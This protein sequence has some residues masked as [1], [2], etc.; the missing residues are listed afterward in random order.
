MRTSLAQVLLAALAALLLAACGGGGGK[1]S[2]P[3]KYEAVIE[4][5]LG[6]PRLFLYRYADEY[7]T[8]R[9]E[10]IWETPVPPDERRPAPPPLPS[11]EPAPG[12]AGPQGV[13]VLLD[14]L[15]TELA[16][17][18]L[19][20]GQVPVSVLGL[21]AMRGLVYR[22]PTAA[23]QIYASVRQTV[24]EA[25]Y[26]TRYAGTLSGE[27]NGIFL[28]VG[29][30]DRFGNLA[31]NR[32]TNGVI[33]IGSIGARVTYASTERAGVNPG[34]PVTI[35]GEAYRVFSVSYDGL[36][37]DESRRRM[38]TGGESGSGTGLNNCYPNNAARAAPLAFNPGVAGLSID[39]GNYV[40]ETCSALYETLVRARAVSRTVAAPGFEATDF[41]IP[42]ALDVSLLGVALT[43]GDLLTRLNSLCEGPDAWSLRVQPRA[44]LGLGAQNLCAD[45]T[46]LH[47][48]LFG[49][50]GVNV[51]AARTGFIRQIDGVPP[52]VS[53]G[54]VLLDGT[55]G[56][57]GT[58]VM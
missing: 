28:W 42:D 35:R 45:G 31:P 50:N 25:G 47:T 37:Y 13:R 8:R 4:A 49:P 10:L 56:G 55:L 46:F 53:Q 18:G 32:A 52:R 23:S 6:S 17:R 51:A 34:V 40:F 33:G 2:P 58:W 15:A 5:D 20:K 24:G 14:V 16:S 19:S 3:F 39:A 36:G 11:F 26:A 9:V 41:V 44:G 29:V 21:D 12:N 54:F 30:N 38:I 7:L 1:D 48:F 43:P 27:A 22:N 57:L